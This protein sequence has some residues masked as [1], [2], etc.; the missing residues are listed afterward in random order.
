MVG[1]F[2][3]NLAM[4]VQA[5]IEQQAEEQGNSELKSRAGSAS[6][7][8]NFMMHMTELNEDSAIDQLLR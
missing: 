5:A 6:G 4:E 2:E 1:N 8:L 3:Q 7:K